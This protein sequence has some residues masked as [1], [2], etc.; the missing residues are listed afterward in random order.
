[1]ILYNHMFTREILNKL[2]DFT[3]KIEEAKELASENLRTAQ[4]RFN[5]VTHK[6][7]REGKE[8]ELTEKVL[9]DE[10]FYIGPASQAGQILEKVHPEVFEAYRKQDQLAEDLKKYCITELGIDY[11]QMK[12]SDYLKMT[13]GMFELLLQEHGITSKKK[14]SWNKL[15]G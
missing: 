13:E 14:S 15:L 9:W 2:H 7:T 4:D 3:Q 5:H 6:L 11:T 8:I 12:L 10:V 1:M